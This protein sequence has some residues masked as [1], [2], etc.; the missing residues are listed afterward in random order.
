ML[1]RTNP[2]D[3][4]SP[5]QFYMTNSQAIKSYRDVVHYLIPDDLAYDYEPC[6][7]TRPTQTT[8]LLVSR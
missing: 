7:I 8:F 2:T 4:I 1:S 5:I 3:S 6:H